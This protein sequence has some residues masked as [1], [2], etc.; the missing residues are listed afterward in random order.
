MSAETQD[1]WRMILPQ[2]QFFVNLHGDDAL[3]RLEPPASVTPVEPPVAAP[4]EPVADA[5]AVEPVVP[6]AEVPVLP[7][8]A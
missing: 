8:A 6:P 5:P 3:K 4:V 1:R 7:T 2:G